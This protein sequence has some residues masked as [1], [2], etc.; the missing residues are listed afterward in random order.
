MIP[1][2]EGLRSRQVDNGNGLNMHVLEAG[3]ETRPAVC[4]VAARFS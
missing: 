3:F 2:P 1:L 4:N